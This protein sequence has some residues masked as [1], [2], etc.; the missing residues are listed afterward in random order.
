V[1]RLRK[2]SERYCK[3]SEQ[4]CHGIKGDTSRKSMANISKTSASPVGLVGTTG[5]LSVGAKTGNG[6]DFLDV[7]IIFKTRNYQ[8]F[9]N[10]SPP[11][12]MPVSYFG[13]PWLGR[14]TLTVLKCPRQLAK[15]KGIIESPSYKLVVQV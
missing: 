2:E 12:T 1:S 3:E 5:L 8:Y 7:T 4:Y 14:T 15:Q 11:S 13:I 10:K 9:K 6:I